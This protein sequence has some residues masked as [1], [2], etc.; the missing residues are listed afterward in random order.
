MAKYD[1]VVIGAG[2]AGLSAAGLLAKEGKS[3]LLVERAPWL[4]G[5]GMMVP[6]EEF[7]VQ[8]GSHLVEDTGSGIM[9]IAEYLGSKIE[10][11]PINTD[12]PVWDHVEEKWGSIRDRYS[13][14]NRQELKKVIKALVDTPYEEFDNWDDKP[15]RAWMYQHTDDQGVV[16]LFEF[17]A[18]L[19]C[20]TDNWYDHSA[21]ENLYVR[22]LHYQEA[23]KGGFSFWPVGGWDGIWNGMA[24]ALIDNGGE[25]RLNTSVS[26][27]VI[28]DDQVKGVMIPR[29][30]RVLPNEIFEEEFVEADC[31]ISTLPVW[32]VLSVVPEESLPDWY[33]AQIKHLAQ[34][35]FRVSWLGLHIATEEPCPAIDRQEL[36]T[37]LH[38]PESR[39]PG[40]MFEQT[41]MDP[42]TAPP[43]VYLY[44]LGGVIPG[45][46]GRDQSYLREMFAKFE[47]DLNRMFPCFENAVWRR[48]HLV[49]D[50]AFGVISKPYLVGQY[51]PD[52][53]A[54]N[55]E[56]LYFA[57]ETFKSRMIGTDR[58]ARAALTV[59]EDYL[60][61]RLWP[62][63]ESWRY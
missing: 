36:C 29:E 24:K 46:K 45:A 58:A 32:N 7:R 23:K 8:I 60:G 28:E 19:E 10:I 5:R 9:K 26:R 52:W 30:P 54:P 48:R 39:L 22:K 2:A 38:A 50:P 37:W 51:R 43:G 6:D 41:A 15:L 13:G 61:R 20:L 62:I 4:G 14:S 63:E 33:A 12:M 3:V 40:F 27:V 31:V 59:V 17:L 53:R 49:F 56:G 34:D 11:G 16:D 42:D 25:Y 55:V 1:V 47:R 21:S 35:K 44:T 18:V 57:S